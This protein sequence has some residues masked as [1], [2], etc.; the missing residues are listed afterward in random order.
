MKITKTLR[1]IAV[2]TCSIFT[3][4]TLAWSSPGGIYRLKVPDEYGKVKERYQG[5]SDQ[6]VVHIQDAHTSLESQENIA[7]L[8]ESIVTENEDAIVTVEGAQGYLDPSDFRAFPDREVRE[9]VSHHFMKEGKFS[10]VEHHAVTTDNPV[11]L[12]GAEN[13]S[14]YY[15]NYNA[16]VKSASLRGEVLALVKEMEGDIL[17]KKGGILSSAL[18]ELMALHSDYDSEKIDFFE[19]CGTLLMHAENDA[20]NLFEYCNL[21]LLRET[22]LIQQ[23]ID[24]DATDAERDAFV[25]FLAEQRITKEEKKTLEKHTKAFKKEKLSQTEFFSYLEH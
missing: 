22:L 2:L 21:A 16:F 6:V 7:K 11:T 23:K 1:V 12:F 3:F 18:L 25:S 5:D 4:T 20:I 8:I 24:F 15:Q 13:K 14:L 10:G 19:Y 17:S 9:N